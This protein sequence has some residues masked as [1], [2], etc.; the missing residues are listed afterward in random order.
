MRTLFSFALL[1]MV[2]LGFAQKP[3]A[4]AMTVRNASVRDIL[5]EVSLRQGERE[6]PVGRPTFLP[7]R[8]GVRPVTRFFG[9]SLPKAHYTITILDANRKRL[10]LFR[11]DARMVRA[12]EKNGMA[13][14][15]QNQAVN[16]T[17]GS[18]R[19]RFLLLP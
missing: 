2:T 18:R 17:I 16:V 9:A 1:L 10:G 14:L 4:P 3:K 7:I 11:V 8:S 12:A 15:V 13:I 19:Q 6:V 5:L